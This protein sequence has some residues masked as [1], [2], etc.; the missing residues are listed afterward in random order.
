MQFVGGN[1]S[2]LNSGLF[3]LRHFADTNGVGVRDTLRVA[4]A[5]LGSGLNNSFTNSGT[6]G[7][8]AVTGG[9]WT[10][11]NPSNIFRSGTLTTQWRSAARCRAT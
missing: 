9:T 11:F 1:N 5:D 2:I 10:K 7:L 6:L 3:D 8:P 4:I